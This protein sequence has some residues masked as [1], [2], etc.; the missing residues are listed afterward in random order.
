ME[1]NIR[2][3]SYKD[4]FG[5]F[6]TV[7]IIVG[8]IIWTG[9]F[10]NNTVDFAGTWEDITDQ[11][12]NIES[13]GTALLIIIIGL[14]VVVLLL[15]Y[16]GIMN[17]RY[18]LT[19]QGIRVK[20]PQ[21]MVISRTIDIKFENI[22]RIYVEKTLNNQILG[23]GN[24]VVELTGIKDKNVSLKSIDNPDQVMQFIM[25]K[26]N[27]HNMQKQYQYTQGAKIDTILNKF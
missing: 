4:F 15:N 9:I 20:E 19:E 7:A 11:T 1:Y 26:Q 8:V 21:M 14:A 6:L 13:V 2:A 10:L 3:N 24:I 27:E 17:I 12:L 5:S 16:L 25:Q 22:T 18:T 23:G